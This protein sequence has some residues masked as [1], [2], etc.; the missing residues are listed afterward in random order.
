MKR[1]HHSWKIRAAIAA[2]MLPMVFWVPS[3]SAESLGVNEFPTVRDRFDGMGTH[4][5]SFWVLPSVETGIVYDSNVFAL[6]NS[7]IDDTFF[8][9]RPT[10]EAKSDFSRHAVDFTAALEH[11][12]YFDRSTESITN[13]WGKLDGRVDIQRDFQFFGGI[14]GGLFHEDRGDI[15][16]PVFATKPIEYGK[17]GIRGEFK[18]SFN[19]LMVSV[20]GS[21]ERYDF[22]NAVSALTGMTIDQ[23]FRDRNVYSVGGRLGYQS[24]PGY[25][26]FGDVRFT[27]EDYDTKGIYSS[28]RINGQGGVAFDITNLI[29][30]EVSAGYNYVNYDNPEFKSQGSPSYNIA[31]IWNPTPLMTLTLDGGQRFAESTLVEDGAPISGSNQSSIKATLDYEVTRRLIVSPM[32]GFIYDDFNQSSWS[33]KTIN[34]G[35]RMDFEVNRYMD[36]G[37][38]YLYSDANFSGNLRDYNRHRVGLFAKARF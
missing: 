33:D 17:A 11:L 21:A 8:Y 26:L 14:S 24:A 20:G 34:A 18:K 28:D 30:G 23:Q 13:G 25:T 9:V 1:K 15:N 6:P 36:V 19:R 29:T 16:S 27:T 12:E 32:V 2:F 10:L 38:N 4:V 22:S 35:L 31:L 37:M 3:A 5:G 7:P